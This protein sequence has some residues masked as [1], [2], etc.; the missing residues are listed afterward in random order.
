VGPSLLWILP[1]SFM[2]VF[3]FYP[4]ANIFRLSFSRAEAGFL[5]PFIEAAASSTVQN[6]TWF[7][8]YQA[9]LSTLITLLIGLPGAY[10]LA[11]YAFRGKSIFLALTTI[12][13]VMPTLVVA[14][15]FNAFLGPRGWLNLFLMD[16]FNLSTAPI[17]FTNTFT[18]ILVAHVFYNTTI[19]LRLVGDFWSHLDPRL[20]HAA[21][22]LGANR[23]KTFR[24]II[25]PL[26]L[27]AVVSASLL[28]FIFNFTSFGVILIL[29]GP[30]LPHWR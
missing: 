9:T 13:F 16:I 3:Y 17:H 27:P 22:M 21:Q 11:R 12:P 24:S 4:L 26:L 10:L 29:G 15:A 1:L 19:V 20:E 28:V 2:A 30:V 6:A 14:A 5:Q 18:A 7:T 8:I 23:L 25:F